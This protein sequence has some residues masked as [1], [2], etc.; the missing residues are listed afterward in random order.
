MDYFAA[1][2]A[3]TKAANAGTDIS[4]VAPI[5]CWE[6]LFP[7][8]AGS[9]GFGIGPG[10]LGC[11]PGNSSFTGTTTATQ[12]MYDMYSCFSGNETTG[13]FVADLLCLPACAQL[14]GQPAGG[15]PFN[16]F[17]N[18]YSSLYAW[19]SVGS[20]VYHAAQF[21]LRHVMT[22][23]LQFDLNYTF[24]KSIDVGSNAERINQFEGGGFA[25]QIINSWFPKQ[26]RSVSDFDTTHAINA[27]WIY[28]L[29]FG[30]GKQF[31][32]GMGKIANALIGGWTISGLWRW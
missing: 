20:S 26:L 30:Q 9:F 17:D 4:Q 1:A 31:G 14:A 12:A 32:S 2:A 3:L 8:A 22:H 25:S 13:L 27:N 18:Q 5:P 23:G 16:F 29:P 7:A 28:E 15:Q 11:A 21:S 6:H 19:R 24:S 10:G